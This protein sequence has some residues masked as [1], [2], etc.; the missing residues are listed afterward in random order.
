TI[1]QASKCKCWPDWQRL[2]SAQPTFHPD[3]SSDSS[4]QVRRARRSSAAGSHQTRPEQ[5]LERGASHP[6]AKP[7]ATWPE[8]QP[9]KRPEFHAATRWDAALVE[10]K[11][12]DFAAALHGTDLETDPRET[13]ACAGPN[14]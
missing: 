7:M 10:L 4:R 13:A 6:Q 3:L 8:K 11:A 5:V 14:L 1:R 9:E 2:Q 12:S